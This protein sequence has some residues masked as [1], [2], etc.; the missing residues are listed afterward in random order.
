MKG[1]REILDNFNLIIE[2]EDIG[3]QAMD[4]KIKNI[5]Q[6]KQ[7]ESCTFVRYFSKLCSINLQTGF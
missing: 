4:M 6:G 5:G 7:L 2:T 3:C 1:L